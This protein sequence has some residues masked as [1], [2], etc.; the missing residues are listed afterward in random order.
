MWDTVLAGLVRHMA[1]FYEDKKR[2]DP[3]QT[4]E[5]VRDAMDAELDGIRA[6]F[7]FELP[8]AEK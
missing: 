8:P 6:V 5:R 4:M 1:R 7:Y 2:L 3:E